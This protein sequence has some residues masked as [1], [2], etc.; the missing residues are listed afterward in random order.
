MLF[1]NE[2]Y[3]KYITTTNILSILPNTV[4]KTIAVFKCYDA[5]DRFGKCNW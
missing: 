2:N 3:G 1:E 5:M 4:S